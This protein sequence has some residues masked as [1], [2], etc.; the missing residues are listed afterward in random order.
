MS[1]PGKLLL[2][3][4]RI[5][6]NGQDFVIKTILINNPI[7]ILPYSEACLDLIVLIFQRVYDNHCQ[8]SLTMYVFS[9][10][11]E[12]KLSFQMPN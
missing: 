2:V 6:I 12:K 10:K 8:L 7:F 3:Y 9:L 11:K 5:S 1:C 4:F